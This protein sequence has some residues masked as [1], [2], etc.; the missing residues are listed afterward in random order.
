MPEV[1]STGLGAAWSPD[2]SQA[3]HASDRIRARSVSGSL[4]GGWP[5]MGDTPVSTHFCVRFLVP[6]IPLT[7]TV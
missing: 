1:R 4:I 2:A 3:A 6:P 5:Y 7:S